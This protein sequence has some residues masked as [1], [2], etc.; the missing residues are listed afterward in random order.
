MKKYHIKEIDVEVWKSFEYLLWGKEIENAKGSSIDDLLPDE[1]YTQKEGL[2]LLGD[3]WFLGGP[4]NCKKLRF[5]A[6]FKRP[7]FNS[8]QSLTIKSIQKAELVTYKL[9]DRILEIELK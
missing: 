6:L 8:T 9:N 5:H 1:V 4:L 3:C 7:K 2:E